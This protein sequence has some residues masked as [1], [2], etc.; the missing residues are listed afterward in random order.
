MKFL[1][2]SGGTKIPIDRVRDITNMSSGTFGAK[3]A[4]ELLKLGHQVVFYKAKGSKSPMSQTIDLA[5]DQRKSGN[6]FAPWHIENTLK[7]LSAWYK[8]R[9]QYMPKYNEFEYSTFDQYQE[10]L[11]FILGVEKPDVTLLSAAVSDYGVENFMDGKIRSNDMFSIQLKQLPKLIYHVKEWAP[12]TKL[13]GFKLLVESKDYELI[14]AAKK[15]IADNKCE[16][17]V[18]NDL[19][20]MKNGKHRIHLVFSKQETITFRDESSD[21]TFLAR[22]VALQSTLL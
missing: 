22:M 11:K 18:A 12:T 8:E 1:I 20:E 14:D 3:I 2:T 5:S 9:A 10:G 4:W 16:M 19:S 7:S 17:I 13:V 15:S 6:S 21:P